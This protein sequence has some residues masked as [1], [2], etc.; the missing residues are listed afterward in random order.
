MRPDN[1]LARTTRT[2]P[3]E[4]PVPP[5]ARISISSI[6][7]SLEADRQVTPRSAPA[8]NQCPAMTACCT[9]ERYHRSTQSSGPISECM[10]AV[11][12]AEF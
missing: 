3:H 1:P 6:P 2:H 12:L 4:Q 8:E 7:H 10:A 11:L 9:H 5:P